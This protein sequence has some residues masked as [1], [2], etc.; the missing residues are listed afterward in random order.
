[1]W[2]AMGRRGEWFNIDCLTYPLRIQLG[3]SQFCAGGCMGIAD[4]GT[5]L[6][7]GPPDEITKI[8]K[9]LGGKAEQGV[10][11]WGGGGNVLCA[12]AGCSLTRLSG[13]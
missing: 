9:Q 6:L 4:T 5:S 8:N 12:M 10:V 3:G 1:M 11:S 2:H 7:V 13:A